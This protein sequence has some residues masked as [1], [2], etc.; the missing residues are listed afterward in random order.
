MLVVIAIMGIG[1]GLVVTTV[2]QVLAIER[3]WRDGIVATRVLRHATSTFAGDALN[4]QSVD[5]ADGSN[6]ASIS[7]QWMYDHDQD[8]STPGIPRTATYSLN[9]DR[10]IRDI[11]GSLLTVAQ[12]V[13]AIQFSRTG[14]TIRLD[15]TLLADQGTTD[16]VSFDTYMRFL[17]L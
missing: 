16:S 13:T 11:D 5:L 2:F 4:T 8:R 7:L 6:A 12:N 17:G 10:L 1:I 3:Y 15:L 9:G 14:R